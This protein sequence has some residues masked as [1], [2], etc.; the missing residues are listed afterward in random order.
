MN[1]SIDNF[2]GRQLQIN[3]KSYRYFGGTSYLGLQT[4]IAF[5]ELFIANIKKYGTNYGASRKSNIQL[6]I[7]KRAETYLAKK[8]GSESCITLSSGYLA[9]Q[10]VSRQFKHSEY[11]C[12]YAP[13]THSALHS[14]NKPCFQS[15]ADLNAMVRKQLLR[16][17]NDKPVVFLDAIDFSGINYPLFI[18]L[19][20]L[21]LDQVTLVV[22]DSHGIGIVGTHGGGVFRDITQLKPKELIVCCSLGKGLG[23]QAGAIFGNKDRILQFM[24]TDFFGGASPATPAAMATLVQADLIYKQKRN[25]LLKNIEFF[26]STTN[27]LSIFHWMKNHPS[28]SFSN[29][30]LTD[31]LHE[32]EIIISNFKYPNETAS[33]FSRIV[34]NASHTK[35]DISLL[36]RTINSFE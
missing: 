22:D 17:P 24:E 11:E 1:Y 23:V 15:Y 5:Q 31:Y 2:P 25:I 27:N 20:Q 18:G 33:F 14:N 30:K 7:F 3:G 16:N 12:Y 6:G 36:S 35:D 34:I 28:F 29:P 9:G 8:V 13:N 26:L 10:F 21:P 19:K 32:N 4:D